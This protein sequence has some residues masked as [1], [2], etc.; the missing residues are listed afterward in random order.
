MNYSKTL[1]GSSYRQR[2]SL[3]RGLIH[4]FMVF[5]CILCA[6]PLLLIISASFTDET[7]LVQQGFRLIPL[8][9]STSA[10]EFLLR[11]PQQIV[12]A[13]GVSLFVTV[14]GAS[15]SLLC[16]S[17]LAYAL[18]R[19]DFKPR[20]LI[21][22]FV[23]FPILFNA[24]MVPFYITM[25][26]TLGLKDTLFALIL[27]PLVIPFFV[28][29][30][31][32]YFASLPRELI[33]AAKLDGGSEWRIFF[34]VV[35][36]LSTPALATVGLFSLLFYWNDLYLSLLFINKPE[37]YNLQYLLYKIISNIQVLQE[38]MAAQGT[39]I[40][41]PLQSVRMAM[42]VLAMGPVLFAYLFVQRY[43][44]KGITL[45]GLKGD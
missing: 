38:G 3:G 19:R 35:V 26:R 7:T 17:L 13:Y 5:V 4:A 44:V 37:L 45:G 40:R 33:E 20:R 22:F 29:L 30:L 8:K 32:T 28:L 9:F 1:K 41:P 2:R 23:F 36:P 15:L 25:V 43:F 34:Q 11:D 39:G 21:S 10:Y 6:A 18:S 16:M 42:A 31:R 14:A 24:G 12:R 27:P